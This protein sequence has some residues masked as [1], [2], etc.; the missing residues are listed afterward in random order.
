MEGDVVGAMPPLLPQSCALSGPPRKALPQ[1][2]WD[3]PILV[4]VMC[5]CDMLARSCEVETQ[6]SGARMQTRTRKRMHVSAL[7]QARRRVHGIL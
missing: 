7:C 6:L 1:L 3:M 5:A 4:A 2:A